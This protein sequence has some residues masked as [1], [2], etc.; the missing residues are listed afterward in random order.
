M[1]VTNTLT[2]N[3]HV[4]RVLSNCAKSV[5]CV[6]DIVSTR[7]KPRVS[8]QRIQR[9]NFGKTDAWI[10]FT[11]TSERERIEA[12]IRRC[13]RSELCSA[14]TQTFAQICEVYDNQLF[15]KIIRYP[16][17][18]LNHLLASVSAAAEN[19]NFRP[20]KHNRLLPER[21]LLHVSLMLILFTEIFT[22]TFINDCAVTTIFTILLSRLRSINLLFNKR[23]CVVV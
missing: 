12:F 20:R 16:C 3:E 18:I 11:R 7:S 15:S 8:T 9:C 10:G 2:V 22:V 1:T 6:K 4:D 5:I 14:E 17:H 19:Y 13:K 23:I 21:S